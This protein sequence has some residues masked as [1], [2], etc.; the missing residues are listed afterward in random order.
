[1]WPIQVAVRLSV[2]LYTFFPLVSELAKEI[3]AGVSLNMSQ[4]RI[5]GANAADQQLEKTIVH[6]NLVPT[7]GKFDDATAFSIYQKFWKRAVFIKSTDFGA[8][9][10]VYVRYPGCQLVPLISNWLLFQ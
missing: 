8:Y 10:M 4:V 9:E 1:M 7:N 3:A 6:I 2:T 5:M